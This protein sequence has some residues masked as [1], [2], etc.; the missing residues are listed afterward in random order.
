MSPAHLQYRAVVR[1]L[2]SGLLDVTAAGDFEPWRPVSGK[3]AVAV[4][5]GLARLVGQ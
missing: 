3:D 1:V 2:A 5:E 4:V